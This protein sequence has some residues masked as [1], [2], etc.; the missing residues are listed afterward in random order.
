MV[1]YTPYMCHVVSAPGISRKFE[2][3]DE[4]FDW[5]QWVAVVWLKIS[6]RSINNMHIASQRRRL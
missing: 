5:M 3:E 2:K 6:A 1:L 4:E